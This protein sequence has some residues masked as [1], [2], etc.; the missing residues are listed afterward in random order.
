MPHPVQKMDSYMSCVN[1]IMDKQ[2]GSYFNVKGVLAK[3]HN[4]AVSHLLITVWWDCQC[5]GRSAIDGISRV[6][7]F[8]KAMISLGTCFTEFYERARVFTNLLRFAKKERIKKT[9]NIK[10]LML[11]I[12]IF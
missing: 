6:V 9:I 1:Y 7:N 8:A 12:Y 10:L 5:R 11:I 2:I 4:P 3:S